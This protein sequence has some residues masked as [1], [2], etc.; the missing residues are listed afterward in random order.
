VRKYG[1]DYP[2]RIERAGLKAVEDRFVFELPKEMV[3][4][5]GLAASEVIY[6]GVRS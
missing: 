5:Y 3:F 1:R 6:V 4:R 2:Q